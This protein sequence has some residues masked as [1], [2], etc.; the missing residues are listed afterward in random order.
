MLNLEDQ[1]A[2]ILFVEFFKHHLNQVTTDAKNSRM[3]E[4][5]TL[6]V[7]AVKVDSTLYHG[8]LK[9]K[10]RKANN[11]KAVENKVQQGREVDVSF[12]VYINS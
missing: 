1:S 7:L 3:S 6:N 2:E 11:L 10:V 4:E 8:S 9:M 12:L 5:L